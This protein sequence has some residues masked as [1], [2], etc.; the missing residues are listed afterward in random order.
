MRWDVAEKI[1]V[2]GWTI[3]KL[4]DDFREEMENEDLRAYVSKGLMV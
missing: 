4:D 1:E 2:W 3:Y